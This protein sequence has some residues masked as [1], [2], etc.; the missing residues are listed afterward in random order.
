MLYYRLNSERQVCQIADTYPKD[1]PKGW[2]HTR[3]LSDL[4]QAIKVADE[5]SELTG[6]LYLG[7]DKG[8]WIS[9]R[10]DVIKAPKIGDQVSFAFNGDYYPDGVIQHISK[11]MRVI[12][13]DSG[14]KYYRRGLSGC[15]KYQQTWSLVVGHCSDK[16]PHF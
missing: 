3:D 7:I 12:T 14:K 1:D 9:P 16:N 6:E 4:G 5:I 15:W 10:F 11:S 2:I 8:E 13:T